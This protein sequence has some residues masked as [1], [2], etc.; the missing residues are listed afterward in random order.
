MLYVRKIRNQVIV[1][2]GRPPFGAHLRVVY[3]EL[4]L[5]IP[6][7]VAPVAFDMEDDALRAA[8][9]RI[10]SSSLKP[11]ASTTVRHR[12]IGSPYH[13]SGRCLRSFSFSLQTNSIT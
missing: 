5:Q 6:E 12:I 2:L 9:G 3:R 4:G 8:V 13:L 10:H 1:R 7:I 11:D